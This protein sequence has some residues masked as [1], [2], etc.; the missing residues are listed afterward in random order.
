[1]A[2]HRRHL[3]PLLHASSTAATTSKTPP[4][5]VHGQPLRINRGEVRFGSRL[6]VMEPCNHLLD[7]P[8]EMRRVLRERGFLYL[9]EVVPTHEVEVARAAIGEKLE[10]AG[11]IS[12]NTAEMPMAPAEP[13]QVG[14]YHTAIVK[15]LQLERH[16]ALHALGE[17][18]ALR[19]LFDRLFEEPSVSSAWKRIRP[20]AP[21][22]FS[23]FHH[24][25]IYMGQG[26]SRLLTAWVPLMPIS[27][28]LGGLAVLERPGATMS[29]PTAQKN[30]ALLRETYGSYD[31]DDAWIRGDGTFSEDPD[32]VLQ[33][34]ERLLTS[35]HYDVGDLVVF[36]LH[37][38][39]GSV[40]NLTAMSDD[41][42]RLRLS[43]DVRYQPAS[44]PA[45]QRWMGPSET[46]GYRVATYEKRDS[47]PNAMRMSDAKEAW[48]LPQLR[49]KL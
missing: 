43:I 26:S 28:S 22:Q 37:V 45:D 33:Y 30:D 46:W 23:G 4:G 6:G 27:L 29:S 5:A 1:M 17:S 44:D 42:G 49:S 35:E 40:T 21:G 19:S 31:V 7:R 48:G 20:I 8:A 24:D 2:A 13:T 25:H 12:R 14:D 39:H 18:P 36:D 15:S 9:K 11:V 41:P 10:A 34:G 38:L 3:S 16:P 47:L 32:E